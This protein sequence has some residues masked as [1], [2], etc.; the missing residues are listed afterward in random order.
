MKMA[1]YI[2]K[3]EWT[4][5]SHGAM[6]QPPVSAS[7][8]PRTVFYLQSLAVCPTYTFSVLTDNLSAAPGAIE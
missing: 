3:K 8:T 6:R 1:Q 4:K 2:Q 5:G 7:K